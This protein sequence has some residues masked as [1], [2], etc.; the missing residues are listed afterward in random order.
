LSLI[1]KSK[2]CRIMNTV[3]SF[4]IAIT[5]AVLLTSCVATVRPSHNFVIVKTL[6]RYHKVVYVRGVKYYKWNGHYH[7]K[8]HRGYV[9][10]S[11]Y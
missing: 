1:K 3:K 8:T 7:K 11:R 5:L 10:V 9:V 2:N 4:F 6:P